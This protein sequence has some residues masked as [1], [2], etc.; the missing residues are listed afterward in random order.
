MKICVTGLRGIPG[1]MGGVETHCEELLPRIAQTHPDL[2]IEVCGR[3]HYIG[4][5]PSFIGRVRITPL[6]S[7]TGK[8]SE[9]IVS[10]LFGIWHARKVR[11]RLLHIH[12]IGPAILTPIARLLGLR[13]VFTHHGADYERAKWGRMARL[14]LRLGEQMGMR[15]SNHVIC[16]SSS[17]KDM[18]VQRY[19]AVADRISFIPNGAATLPAL[20]RSD[21]E[22]LEDYGLKRQSY[23]LSVA[24]L[25]PEKGLACLIQAHAESETKK[26]LVIAGAAMHGDAYA[27]ILKAMAGENVLFLGAV[28]RNILGALYRNAAIFI[29]P[30]FHEGLPIAA[31]EAISSDCPTLLSNIPAN[32]D[33]GLP[34][35]HYF[36]VGDV[37]ALAERL[38]GRQK[39][40]GDF[41]E[42]KRRFDWDLIAEETVGVYHKAGRHQ[43][44]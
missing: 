44:A 1:V 24:R 4:A 28:S 3:A 34:D 18:M 5:E 13:V 42:V 41:A 11:A 9:A 43:G 10:T 31:L 37:R 15:F 19:P 6:P 23:L 27:D 30:S 14:F 35:G 17:L 8:S 2:E 25:V 21:A 40:P 39:L 20:D 7:T 22:I 33:L 29:L 12:A 16:V 38:R 32:R 26:T 36:P